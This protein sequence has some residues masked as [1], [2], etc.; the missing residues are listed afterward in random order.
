VPSIDGT[1][2]AQAMRVV[3]LQDQD[4]YAGVVEIDAV[5]DQFGPVIRP[6]GVI[7]FQ[8][9]INDIREIPPYGVVHAYFSNSTYRGKIGFH[10]IVLVSQPT[11]PCFNGT[12]NLKPDVT[13]IPAPPLEVSP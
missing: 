3:I 4:F 8:G 12:T 7:G 11:L 5:H 6:P 10:N 9:L 13:L 1:Q 2:G